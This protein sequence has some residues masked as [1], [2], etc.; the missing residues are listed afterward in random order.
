MMSMASMTPA[1]AASPWKDLWFCQNTGDGTAKNGTEEY[2]K[3]QGDCG[4]TPARLNLC[5]PNGP[6]T[7]GHHVFKDSNGDN[8]WVIFEE[9]TRCVKN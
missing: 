9:R 5:D 3:G 8:I 1:F 7:D 4:M 2:V 6:S